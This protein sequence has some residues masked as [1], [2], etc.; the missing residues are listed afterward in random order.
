MK[1][2]V[3]LIGTG[4]SFIAISFFLFQRRKTAIQDHQTLTLNAV[5][6]SSTE[7]ERL[8][9]SEG[10]QTELR[11]SPRKEVNPHN[12]ETIM[13][14]IVTN[15]GDIRIQLFSDK[16]PITVQNFLNYVEDSFFEGTIFHRVVPDFV[17]QGGGYTESM[18]QKSTKMPIVNEAQNGLSNKRGTVAMARTNDPNSATSQFFI[19]LSD[20]NTFLDYQSGKNGQPSQDG[21]AVFGE[22]IEGMEIVDQMSD[23]KNLQANSS[24]P[25]NPVKILKVVIEES[26]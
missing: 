18:S 2:S 12:Q 19:N 7:E 4:L 25:K 26:N 9:E 5:P 8:N 1:R 21:Y 17:V 10:E 11:A 22:V 14:K 23:P 13:V 3:I 15:L 20:A 24:L 16:A 6:P